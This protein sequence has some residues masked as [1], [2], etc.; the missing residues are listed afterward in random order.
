MYGVVVLEFIHDMLIQILDIMKNT[1]I[2]EAYPPFFYSSVTLYDIS[3]GF[4]TVSLIMSIFSF[5]DD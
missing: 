2:F 1:V 5:N 4:L 3:L